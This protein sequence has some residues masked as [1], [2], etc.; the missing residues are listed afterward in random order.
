[1]GTV[2][3]DK[4]IDN[5]LEEVPADENRFKMAIKGISNSIL[6]KIAIGLLALLI[7]AGGAYFFF[8]PS[9]EALPETAASKISDS[10]DISGLDSGSIEPE[11]EAATALENS[12][13]NNQNTEQKMQLLKMREEAVALKEENL[14]MKERLSKLEGQ[15]NSN[16][17]TTE[18]EI[19]ESS[20]SKIKLNEIDIKTT[21]IIAE[22]KINQYSNLYVRNQTPKSQRQ[23]DLTPPPEPKWGKF[24]PHY[25]EK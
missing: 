4:E 12:T 18:A 14:K 6:I 23:R 25:R 22:S 8:M 16:L 13:I 2:M 19:A 3:A 21:E 10:T 7:I 5:T 17:A 1:M 24:D 9:D 20:A 11:N 15:Q